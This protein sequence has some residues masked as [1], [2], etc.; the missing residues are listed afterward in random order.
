MPTKLAD[1]N[2]FKMFPVSNLHL[3][4]VHNY[5]VKTTMN[6]YQKCFDGWFLA[7]VTNSFKSAKLAHQ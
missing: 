3:A 4:I 5:L 2:Y 6:Q 7:E 1:L